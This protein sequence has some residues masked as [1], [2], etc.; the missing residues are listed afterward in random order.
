[1]KQILLIVLALLITGCS[2][3]PKA[4]QVDT[5]PI[6]RAPIVLPEV[7]LFT[8]RTVTWTVVTPENVN[9]LIADLSESGSQL[10][11]FA[12]TAEGY[13]NLSLNM[14]DIIKLVQQQRAIIAAYQQYY[15]QQ[16]TQE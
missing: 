1:M 2:N 10:V 9:N 6:Q 4:I 13:E 3:T 11:F 15:E 14:A 12:V 8:A 7:D 16:P 5:A